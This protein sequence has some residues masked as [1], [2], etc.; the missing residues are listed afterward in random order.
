AAPYPNLIAL[1]RVIGHAA[2][3]W[4]GA[5]AVVFDDAG[6]LLLQQRSDNGFWGL[7]GGLLDLGESLA[8]TARRECE[9]ETGLIVEPYALVGCQ[10]GRL[11]TLPNGHQLYALVALVACRATGGQLHT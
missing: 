2:L 4:P 5:S 9:E 3:V 8:H 10:G 11:A 1:R 7:P 6:R